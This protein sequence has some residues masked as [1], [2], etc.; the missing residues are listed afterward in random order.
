MELNEMNMQAEQL[1]D[2]YRK[3][4]ATHVEALENS[5]LN[6]V[7]GV[8]EFHIVQLGKQLD[9][10]SMY[11]KICEANGTLNNLGTLPRIAFDVITATMGQSIIP[12]I[13]SVQAIQSQKGIVHF[14]NVAA[15]E[16]AG[17]LSAGESIVDPRTGTKTP[18]G[19]SSNIVENAVVGTGDGTETSFSATLDPK[20]S[21]SQFLS[22][23]VDGQASIKAEDMGP[24]GGDKSIGQ[25]Y[26]QGVHGTV[27][28]KTGIIDL[29]FAVAPLAGNDILVSY[30]QNLEDA[31]DIRKI[32]SYWDSQ[33]IEARVY[34]LKATIGMLQAF[35]LQ[36]EYGESAMDELSKDLV[37]A[38]NMEIGGDLIRKLRNEAVGSTTFSK[39]PLTGTSLFEHKMTYVNSIYDADSTM[40]GNAG[41]GKISVVVAGREHCALVAS[42]PGFQSLSDG[43]TLGAHVFGK[44]NDIVYIRVPEDNLIG[45]AG[46][47]IGLFKGD[48]PFEA[49][50]VY[51]PFMPLALTS[52]LPELRNPLVSQKAAA[53]MAGV[54]V[55]VPQY[56]T[57]L[58]VVA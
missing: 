7:E 27:N 36:K 6:K 4:Y 11:S 16:T 1:A 47:G 33:E 43:R 5:L 24:K 20:P 17:N 10:F 15:F 51:S 45:G 32:E 30:Q 9:A 57:H 31:E 21:R 50:C 41:R 38:V 44:Y 13:A 34:A 55:L 40:I 56:A 37:R 58:N 25:I 19:Y 14:K 42:L 26:G 46:K 18:S 28:Y 3:K 29:E 22:V 12:M 8:N 35:T 39:T 48:N 54:N 49:A 23:A 52:D 2:G 53:T